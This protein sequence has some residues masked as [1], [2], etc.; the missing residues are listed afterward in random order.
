MKLVLWTNMLAI[1]RS[2]D[3]RA[4][5]QMGHDVT[6]VAGCE[7]IGA[8]RTLGWSV[9]DVAPA[10]T[11]VDP[12]A[13]TI[14]RLSTMND[15]DTVHLIGGLKS[16]TLGRGAFEACRKAGTR[17]ALGCEGGDPRG[18][19]G[20]ARRMVHAADRVRFGKDVDFMLAM[21]RNGVTWYRKRGWPADKVFNYAYTTEKPATV[22]SEHGN[23][24][25]GSHFRIAYL[26]QLIHR[27]GV[28]VLIKAFGRLRTHDSE[29]LVIGDG[30]LRGEYER[31]AS[32][33]G[34]GSRTVFLGAMA[35]QAALC[36]LADSDVLVLPSRFDG[37]GAVVNEALMRGVP[38][39][40]SDR[41][42]ASDLVAAPW[43]GEVFQSGSVSALTDALEKWIARG[44]KTPE[45]SERIK[46]WSHCIEGQSV[47][48]Y[49]LD[50]VSASAGLRPRPTPPW[51]CEGNSSRH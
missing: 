22:P 38:V 30:P 14:D 21:G 3:M 10:R 35:N 45:A 43:R 39:V 24:S 29:F 11:I 13:E 37:W 15:N 1:H 17:I 31:L 5:A 9:P 50:V 47:A 40:C 42:G 48:A 8:R 34:I 46:A 7:V 20:L 6:V 2:A 28:D 18:I 23:S 36:Q 27:K 19:K 16:R 49:F 4:L 44:K 12:S 26:G 25:A 32:H 51:L 41:C 33:H